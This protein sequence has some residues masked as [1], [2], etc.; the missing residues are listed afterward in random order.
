MLP[1]IPK[2]ETSCAPHYS[3]YSNSS[4]SVPGWH[5]MVLWAYDGAVSI[6]CEEMC[7]ASRQHGRWRHTHLARWS[8]PDLPFAASLVADLEDERMPCD[9]RWNKQFRPYFTLTFNLRVKGHSP[10][11]L[12]HPCSHFSW[13]HSPRACGTVPIM[14]L[15]SPFPSSSPILSSSHIILHVLLVIFL[16]FLPLCDSLSLPNLLTHF[17][18]LECTRKI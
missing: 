16:L 9:R 17:F 4:V 6:W 14:P 5:M 8:S 10:L 12:Q 2:Q 3:P 1:Q 13:F 11:K 7:K 18:Q 15:F